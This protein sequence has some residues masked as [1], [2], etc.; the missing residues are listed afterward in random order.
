MNSKVIK[1]YNLPKDKEVIYRIEVKPTSA[2]VFMFIGG[3]IS[4][5]YS[6]TLSAILIGVAL[7]GFFFLP[8]KVLIEFTMDYVI[9]YNRA[10][11]NDCVIVYYDE[12]VSWQYIKGRKVDRL[13]IILD[14]GKV[15]CV[16]CFSRYMVC[17]YMNYFAKDK[18]VK[19]RGL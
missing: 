11:K 14:D 13:E 6:T 2:L 12:I 18:Q 7:F 16:E 5:Y 9:L 1:T 10:S 8:S 19:K 17:K 3:V 15:E 4:I